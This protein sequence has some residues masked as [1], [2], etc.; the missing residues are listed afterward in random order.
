MTL[1]T[2]TTKGQVT[3]P[4]D[5]REHLHVDEGDQIDFAI[6]RDGAVV[7]HRMTGSAADLAGFLYDPGRAPVSLE[8]MDQAIAGAAAERCNMGRRRP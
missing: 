7:V 3:I 1:A 6:G 5:I 8:E 4:K 2:L